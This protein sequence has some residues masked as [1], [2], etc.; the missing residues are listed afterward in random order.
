MPAPQKTDPAISLAEKQKSRPRSALLRG[1]SDRTRTCSILLPK[2]ARYQLRHTSLFCCDRTAPCEV[3]LCGGAVR[4]PSASRSLAE[5]SAAFPLVSKLP[6]VNCLDY[7]TCSILLPKQARAPVA[8]KPLSSQG[9]CSP[10][11]KLLPLLFARF[12]CHLQ[13]S[14][15]SPIAPHLV[16]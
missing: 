8:T 15:T 12:I 16:V 9:A 5:Q 2:Q 13:R 4:L 11:G 7:R 10:I 14:Q 6:D 1:R 3:P